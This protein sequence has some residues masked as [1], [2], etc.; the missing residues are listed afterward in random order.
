MPTRYRDALTAEAGGLLTI[1]K[2]PDGCL[3]VFPRPVWEQFRAVIVAM[4]QSEQWT[5][6]FFLGN[7]MDVEIDATGRVLV[8]PELRQAA[9]LDK[10]VWLMGMGKYLELWDR[11]TYDAKEAKAIEMGELQKD[12][13]KGMSF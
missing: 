11:A 3:W 1:T 5:R 10:D 6:R 2:H 12:A 8:A 9:G 13:F 4:P 7:A